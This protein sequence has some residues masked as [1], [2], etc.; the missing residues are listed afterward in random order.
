MNNCSLLIIFDLIFRVQLRFPFT[1]CQHIVERIVTDTL[2]QSLHPLLS[3]FI[4]A[5]RHSI[6]SVFTLDDLTLRVSLAGFDKVRTATGVQFEAEL[7]LSIGTLAYRNVLQGYDAARFF[8]RGVFEIVK[9]IVV[10]DEPAAFPAFVA[11][12]LFPEPALL[13]GV[14]EGVHEV[15]AIVFGNFERFRFNTFV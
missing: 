2:S 4:T 8:V 11:A 5:R 1:I 13:V 3:F 6:Y 10:E 15:V 12:S 9:A 14:E 7:F